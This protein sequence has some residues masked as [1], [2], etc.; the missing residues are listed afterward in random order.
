[1][2]IGIPM[3]IVA[4]QPGTADC[5]GMGQAAHVDMALVG[6]QPVGTWL[7]VF[8]GTAREVLSEARAAEI[9]NALRALDVAMQG[10]DAAEIDSLFPD[11]AGREPELPDFL[12]SAA[13][14]GE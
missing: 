14:T 3:Q 8:L 10:G 2:C 7:L 9:G 4:A 1:M 13:R 6:E 11:L 5:E 12:K